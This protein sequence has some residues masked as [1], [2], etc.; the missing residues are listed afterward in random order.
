LVGRLAGRPAADGAFADFLLGPVLGL[1]PEVDLDQ[2]PG[3]LIAEGPRDGLQFRELG[4]A[5]EPVGVKLSA[6]F[7]GDL[8]QAGVEFIAKGGG[9]LAHLIDLPQVE[10]PAVEGAR[11]LIR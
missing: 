5:G 7:P 1:P 2:L 4:A 9:V 11:D 8:T 3:H 6:Q 10:G